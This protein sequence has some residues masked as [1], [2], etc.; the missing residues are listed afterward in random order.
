MT[1]FIPTLESQATPEQ[2]AKWLDKARRL[3]IIGTYA[4]TEMGHGRF[5]EWE[6][7][8]I[9]TAQ[10]EK[11]EELFV[12]LQQGPL[13]RHCNLNLGKSPVKTFIF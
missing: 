2:Q 8:N 11:S 12:H 10:F 5:E 4:Q 3:E 7:D 13:L 1:L 9:S 6:S